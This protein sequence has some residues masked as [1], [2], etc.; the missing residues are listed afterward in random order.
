MKILMLAKRFLTITAI[1]ISSIT[2][3]QASKLDTLIDVGIM[4]YDDGDKKDALHTWQKV[5]KL[6]S[7]TSPTYGTVLGNILYYYTE[8]K[9][10]RK[11]TQYFN[12]IFN[13]KIN[14]KDKR[15]DNLGEPYK[16]Y[17]FHAAMSLAAYFANKKEFEKALMYVNLADDKITY[18]NSSL[19]AIKYRKV[20]LAFWKKRLYKDLGK[21]DSGFFILVK[22]AFEYD[23]QN[24]YKDWVT[25]SPGNDELELAQEIIR[26]DT[27]KQHFINLKLELDS[28]FLALTKKQQ[29]DI[30][31]IS[32]KFR[33]MN[34]DIRTYQNFAKLEDCLYYLK[35]SYFYQ[36]LKSKSD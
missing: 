3:G 15:Y 20:D 7:D 4:Q 28:S 36:Y 19:T 9:N 23:Y 11:A 16:N 34:Y 22:R 33:N 26:S 32:F 8:E 24:M 31:Y 2:F 13:S 30:D 10:D 25:V 35:N 21:P 18:E 1:L 27:S 29:N 17:R 14:D 12:T 5:E 6:A